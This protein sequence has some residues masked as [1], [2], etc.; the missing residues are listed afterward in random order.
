MPKAIYNK[1]NFTHLTSTPTGQF[2]SSLSRREAEDIR[3]KVRDYFIPVNFVELDMDISKETPL[4][5][6]RPLLST[7]RATINVGA[8]EICFNINGKEEMFPFH[9]KTEQCSMIK[10]KYGPN[11]QGIKEVELTLHKMDS[12][13]TFMKALIKEDQER[14]DKRSGEW[15]AQRHK[16]KKQQ[17]P[18]SA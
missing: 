2:L 1:L 4:I 15:K 3:V 5:L 13:I 10:I 9:P 16:P 12:L 7:A 6:G 8:R 18:K 17:T 11:P 14:M